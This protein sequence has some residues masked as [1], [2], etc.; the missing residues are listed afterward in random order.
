MLNYRAPYSCSDPASAATISPPQPL[1]HRSHLHHHN[2][3]HRTHN[4]HRLS[5]HHRQFHEPGTVDS[6]S[7]PGARFERRDLASSPCSPSTLVSKMSQLLKSSNP[8]ASCAIPTSTSSCQIS[9]SSCN[10]SS[11]EPSHENQHLLSRAVSTSVVSSSSSSS[12]S[13]MR[14]TVICTATDFALRP[15]RTTGSG[16]RGPD[17]KLRFWCPTRPGRAAMGAAVNKRAAHR[18][19]PPPHLLQGVGLFVE[20]DEDE[21]DEDNDDE[22]SEEEEDDDD[23]SEDD[24]DDEDNDDDNVYETDVALA[25]RVS[26]VSSGGPGPANDDDDDCIFSSD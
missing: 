16:E 19:T 7:T 4:H 22:Y 5:S 6:A 1:D 14:A 26:C 9:S 18:H 25:S 24:Q 20:D 13:S 12:S 23:Y 8:T 2:H 17:G 3:H 11:S 21:D 15:A 10:P